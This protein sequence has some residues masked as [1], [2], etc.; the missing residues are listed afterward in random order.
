MDR[1]T[2]GVKAKSEKFRR[3]GHLAGVEMTEELRLSHEVFVKRLYRN[4]YSF[5]GDL[6]VGLKE[7]EVQLWSIIEKSL[8]EN[9]ASNNAVRILN[10]LHGNDLYLAFACAQHSPVAWDRFTS[11]YR[12]YIHNLTAFVCPVKGLVYELAET[13]LSDLFLPDRSGYSRIASYDGRSSLATWLRAIISYR[14]INERERKFNGM[15]QLNDDIFEKVDERALL[16]IEMALRS[17]R[18]RALIIDSLK[19]VCNKL[20]DRERLMLLLRYDNCLKLGEIGHLF[21]LHQATIARQIE[22][23]QAKI[24]QEVVSLLTNKYGLSQAAIDEC[25]AE[26]VENPGYSL[27]GLIKHHQPDCG[28]TEYVV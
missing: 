11:I 6:Q 10:S 14:A 2:M 20:T 13:I 17:S 23:V 28:D 3:I 18:Y 7:F 25:L 26:I 19:Q 16:S 4:G 8:G 12:K 24:R 15:A 27:L 5:H 22:R 21:G 1:A 9:I